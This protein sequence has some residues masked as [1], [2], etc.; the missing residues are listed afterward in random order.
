MLRR[1]A[2]CKIRRRG[3]LILRQVVFT[4]FL[5]SENENPTTG[6]PPQHI[7]QNRNCYQ[8]NEEWIR[9]NT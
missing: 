1:E 8:K 4:L 5:L 3:N 6:K 2:T 7:G 9:K